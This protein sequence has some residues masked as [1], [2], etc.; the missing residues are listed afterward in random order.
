MVRDFLTI[1]ALLHL[2]FFSL[3]VYIMHKFNM[4]IATQLECRAF[5]FVIRVYLLYVVSSVVCT[6]TVYTDVAISQK[7]ANLLWHFNLLCQIT[8]AISLYTFAI[9]RHAAYVSKLRWFTP[10][11]TVPFVIILILLLSSL[12]TGSVLSVSEDRRVAYGPAFF[13]VMILTMLYFLAVIFYAAAKYRRVTSYVARRQ[14]FVLCASVLF[15]FASVAVDTV[16]RHV[17]MSILPAATMCAIVFLYINMQE[18]RIYSD[19]LTGMN[20]RRKANEYL[21]AR[22]REVSGDAPLYIYMCDVNSFK[23]INDG[24]GHAEGDRA[25]V[26][27]ANAIKNALSRR[28]GFAARFG[29]DEFLLALAPS[30]DSDG[31]DPEAVIGDIEKKL[32]KSCERSNKP[33]N[34][35]LSIGYTRCTDPE[36]TLLDC[37]RDADEML[38]ERKRSYHREKTPQ[39]R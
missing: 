6:F 34:V 29:G 39:S 10:L 26:L 28:D 36:K 5:K 37:V 4:D 30:P 31:F 20:N 24:Y 11:S 14:L 1:Y 15:V 12:F 35:T 8:I 32:T 9:F 16:F 2:F 18:S 25:L 3:V 13:P 33:Y 19:A 23:K 7:L 17:Y 21:G 27:A 22:L 38:Y